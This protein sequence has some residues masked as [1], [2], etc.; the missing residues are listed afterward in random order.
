MSAPL[1]PPPP[2]G[3]LP[4]GLPPPPPAQAAPFPPPS[5]PAG[6]ILESQGWDGDQVH[7]RPGLIRVPGVDAPLVWNQETWIASDVT[8]WI[9]GE[10]HGCGTGCCIAGWIDLTHPA[11]EDNVL[12]STED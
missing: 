11:E 3:P 12:D 10:R 9:D 2:A 1:T 7:L 8:V 4:R 6:K 5:T